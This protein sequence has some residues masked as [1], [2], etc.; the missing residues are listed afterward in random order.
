MYNFDSGFS[1]NSPYIK[2]FLPSSESVNSNSNTNTTTYHYTS[3]EACLSIIQNK[4]VRFTDVR[5]LN[6]KTEGIYF[7]KVL[8]DFLDKYKGK[9][10]NFEVVVN[11]LLKENDYDKIRN[12]E[13]FSIT[14]P[15]I[16]YMPYKP[17]RTFVFC[18][19]T[20]ADSLNMWNYYVNNGLY[21]GYNIGFQIKEL[22]KSFDTPNSNANDAFVVYYGRVLYTEKLQFEEI[23]RIAEVLE[24]GIIRSGSESDHSKQRAM[25]FVQLWIRNYIDSRGIFFKHPKFQS[26]DEYRIIIEIADDRI[27]KKEG[28]ADK[29]FGEHNKKMIEE[30]TTKKGLIVPYLKITFSDVSINRITV[31]PMI[32]FDVAKSSIKEVLKISNID[33]VKII[34]SDVPVRF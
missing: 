18:T 2:S 22:L 26:E 13:V 24:K 1:F 6:D 7:V 11:N 3:P 33:N 29:Y 34:K 14:Y 20:Q 23:Q 16:P 15:E 10:P 27:P 8:L 25:L 28:D 17:L 31:A 21:Q 4:T 19:S 12:L 9:Y 5:Y 32:E 30:F